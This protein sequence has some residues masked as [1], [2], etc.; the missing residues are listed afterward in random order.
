MDRSK[1]TAWWNVSSSIFV[2]QISLRT[3]FAQVGLHFGTFLAVI[4]FWSD[5]LISGKWAWCVGV[6]CTCCCLRT[7][8]EGCYLWSVVGRWWSR[9][10]QWCWIGWYLRTVV[11]PLWLFKSWHFRLS[12]QHCGVIQH[13]RIDLQH[14]SADGLWWLHC[15]SW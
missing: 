6:V 4:Y 12:L 14:R 15:M 7:L 3:S 11:K 5:P 8:V 1:Q 2:A 10:I 9:C 13:A